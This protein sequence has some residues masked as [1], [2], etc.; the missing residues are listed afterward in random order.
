MVKYIFKLCKKVSRDKSIPNVLPRRSW[1][2]HGYWAFRFLTIFYLCIFGKKLYPWGR[3]GE[4]LREDL[5]QQPESDGA[6]T[7]TGPSAAAGRHTLLFLWCCSRWQANY[8]PQ[9]G[10]LKQTKK[11]SGKSFWVKKVWVF[12]MKAFHPESLFCD[13]RDR[14]GEGGRGITLD[15]FCFQI[16]KLLADVLLFSKEVKPSGSSDCGVQ[17][18]PLN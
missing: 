8:S 14:R 1:R 7:G 3:A 9:P 13:S 6:G 15:L 10:L 16:S 4:R 18:F 2:G 11:L 17:G 12:L 5:S